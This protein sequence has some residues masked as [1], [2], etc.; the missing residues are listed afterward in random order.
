MKSEFIL[1]LDRFTYAVTMRLEQKSED[2]IFTY[3]TI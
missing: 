2:Y 1:L 3:M